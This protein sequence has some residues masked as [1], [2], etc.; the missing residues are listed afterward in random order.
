MGKLACANFASG[1]KQTTGT[2]IMSVAVRVP[3]NANNFASN[4]EAKIEVNN[5]KGK[6]NTSLKSYTIHCL[7]TVRQSK[8]RG[9]R[10]KDL[11]KC[12]TC[13][14]AYIVEDRKWKKRMIFALNNLKNS[15]GSVLTLVVSF[16]L[17]GLLASCVGIEV[18]KHM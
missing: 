16:T 11:L 7:C 4:V 2:D 8:E 6:S 13:G 17:I 9:D 15:Y 1:H 10:A 12:D 5:I 18:S 3:E 14:N